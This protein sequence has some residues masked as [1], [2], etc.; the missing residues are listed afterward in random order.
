[1]AHGLLNGKWIRRSEQ[2]EEMNRGKSRKGMAAVELALMLPVVAILLLTMLEGANAMRAYSTLVEASREG[3]RLVLME[4]NGHNVEPLVAA[5]TDSLHGNS[6]V[7]IVT[8]DQTGK[9][10]TVEVSYDYQPFGSSESL[11]ALM[12]DQGF[13]LH[14]RTTMPLP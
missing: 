10:V 12:G 5:L 6:A 2:G 3:A 14:A 1:M 7:A 9:T 13:Q 8:T 4:G 11:D